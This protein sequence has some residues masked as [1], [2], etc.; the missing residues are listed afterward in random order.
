MPCDLPFSIVQD[1]LTKIG[2]LRFMKSGKVV[3]RVNKRPNEYIDM[4]VS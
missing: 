1:D 4:D 3:L 2:K